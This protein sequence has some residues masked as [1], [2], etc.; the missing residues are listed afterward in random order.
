MRKIMQEYENFAGTMYDDFTE[1]AKN[2]PALAK[3]LLKNAGNGSWQNDSVYVYDS[4][5]DFA[6]YEL[7]EGWYTNSSLNFPPDKDYRG[8]PNPLAY[9]DLKGLGLA[10]TQTWDDSCHYRSADNHVITT[11]WKCLAIIN[12][13]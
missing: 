11:C 10:L 9:I 3:E 4:L 13:S 7:T 2:K 12:H 1:F 5:Q 6:F 8:A